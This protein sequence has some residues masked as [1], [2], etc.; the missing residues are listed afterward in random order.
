MPH[1]ITATVTR[2]VAAQGMVFDYADDFDQL[3]ASIAE[4][5][6]DDITAGRS[7]VICGIDAPDRSLADDVPWEPFKKH[8]HAL[9]WAACWKLRHPESTGRI[10]LIG[11]NDWG[12]ETPASKLVLLFSAQVANGH[13]LIGGINWLRSP[14]PAKIQVWLGETAANQHGDGSLFLLRDTIWN[15]LTD[16]KDHHGISNVLGAFLLRY[17]AGWPVDETRE[18]SSLGQKALFTQLASISEAA[19]TTQRVA[20]AGLSDTQFQKWISRRLQNKIPAALLF[21]DMAALWSYVV[22]GALGF[23]SADLRDRL[24][25]S[26]PGFRSIVAGLPSRLQSYSRD[27]RHRLAQG[28]LVFEENPRHRDIEFVLLLD[29][30]LFGAHDVQAETVF[31]E[32][33]VSLGGELSRPVSVND[34]QWDR[35]TN[36][37]KAVKEATQEGLVLHEY[38]P[39]ITLLPRLLSLLD[40]LLPIVIF[41]ST[42]RR[43]LL[44][45]LRGYP[46]I[47]TDFVKPVFTAGMGDWRI[48]VE[49]TMRAFQDAMEKAAT[50]LAARNAVL[51]VERQGRMPEAQGNRLLPPG[52]HGHFVEI[53]FDESGP[54]PM[55]PPPHDICSGGIVVIRSLNRNGVP[56]VTDMSLWQSLMSAGCIWGWCANTPQE[57]SGPDRD[58][59]P[60]P[61][62]PKGSDLN[63]GQNRNGAVLFEAQIN[64]INNALG[65]F[66][67][68]FPFAL[69]AQHSSDLPDWMLP[70]AMPM[71][72]IAKAFD[73]TL[74]NLIRDVIEG[75]V[76]RNAL[77]VQALQH[78]AS[79]IAI[80][81]AERDY[82]FDLDHRLFNA[83]G[84][85]TVNS[86][87][88]S[89]LSND[90]YRL[91]ADTCSRVGKPWPHN[92]RICSARAVP[93]PD[94]GR[95]LLRPGGVLPQQLHYFADTISHIALHDYQ[96]AVRQSET[97][98]DFFNSGWLANY[99]FS[100]IDRD[101]LEIA[102]SWGQGDHV[103]ALC[104]AARLQDANINGVSADIAQFL[105][106]E[107]SSLLSHEIAD[108]IAR[109][110]RK[111]A[112]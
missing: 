25:L 13:W 30:R 93:L 46:N 34:D 37:L 102:R 7:I 82:P 79:T 42:H 71:A 58:L 29:L 52:E 23:V 14:D 27:G 8:L 111:K 1:V 56:I 84:I 20:Q 76:F 35:F 103:G 49:N 19:P 97:V 63:F 94:F 11:Q 90:G 26:A 55:Q 64:A 92:A 107:A 74:H 24:T 100:R 54:H 66:G 104:S 5:S 17:Q 80:D 68:V 101:L 4:N 83:F 65:G 47:V 2:I 112:V 45:P 69:I 41:S 21:D 22:R 10:L 16:A 89:I 72:A 32:E 75:I 50:I 31:F 12:V 51:R 77:V 62:M 6:R 15:G 39:A 28:D 106:N 61:F 88:K 109:F 91:T 73:L 70:P 108:L 99:R 18:D 36:D 95:N 43:S 33:L 44:D 38:P 9:A 105:G 53:F 96:Q 60:P 98:R 81:L 57:Y 86:R 67:L 40:P 3:W 85:S 78:K 87:R 59:S 48:T 110:M